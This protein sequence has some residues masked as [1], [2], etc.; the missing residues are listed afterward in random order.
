MA[1]PSG[2]VL[3]ISAITLLS[4]R[5][6]TILVAPAPI[7]M[8]LL[9]CL[10]SL[11]LNSELLQLVPGCKTRLQLQDYILSRRVKSKEEGMDSRLLWLSRHLLF[12]RID[13]TNEGVHGLS[14]ALSDILVA[15]EHFLVT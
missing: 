7:A 14:A 2:V 13:P 5:A 9:F 12:Q 10:E 8:M 6:R 3:A 4:P 15:P 11:E 1:A